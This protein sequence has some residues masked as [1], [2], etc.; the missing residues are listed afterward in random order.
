MEALRFC[1]LTGV[2]EHT[3]VARLIEISQTRPD[4]EWGVLCS[5]K[6]QDEESGAGRYPRMEWIEQFLGKV[7]GRGVRIAIHLCGADAVDFVTGDAQ[8][9]ALAQRFDRAQLNVRAHE[10]QYHRSVDHRALERH[11]RDYCH[12]HSK[13]AI[14]QRNHAN[15]ALFKVASRFVLRGVE[16]LH[17][18]SGGRGIETKEWPR[19]DADDSRGVRLGYAGGLGPDNIA[20]E[21]P[22][23]SAAAAQRPYWIDGENKYRIDDRFDLDRCELTLQDVAD[24]KFAQGLLR[25]EELQSKCPAKTVAALDGFWLDWYGGVASG[26]KMMVPPNDAVRA[27][28]FNRYES[29]YEAMQPSEYPATLARCIEDSDVTAKKVDGEWVGVTGDGQ[30]VKAK[31]REDGMLRAQIV[32]VFGDELPENPVAHPQ[33]VEN[34]LGESYSSALL[35][36]KKS[37]PRL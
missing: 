12:G 24:F 23:I 26:Y 6:R 11:L 2:D 37:K 25:F 4:V 33:F 34:W 5:R 22:R 18:A 19:L 15:E 16:F 21:L 9:N 20:V 29:S 17:D 13:S 14:L 32:S 3:D 27:M 8:L 31:S 7:E 1:T 10:D 36:D 28:A 35:A 30:T